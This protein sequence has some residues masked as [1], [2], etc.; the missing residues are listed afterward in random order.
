L[1]IDRLEMLEGRELLTSIIKLSFEST[2][3]NDSGQM[4][5][6]N[7]NDA[8]LYTGGESKDLGTLIGSNDGS[9]AVGINDSG[10]VVGNFFTTGGMLHVFLYSGGEMKDLGKLTLPG[11]DYGV[12]TGI[13]DSGQVVGYSDLP[14]IHTHAYLYS[15]GAMKDLGSLPG[16]VSYSIAN[17]INDSG[18]VVGFSAIPTSNPLVS[19]N[20]A[21]L[22][23]GGAM[24]DLRT[25]GGYDSGATG[26]NGSGQVVGWS[27]IRPGGASHAFLYSGG[28]MKDLGTLP[29]GYGSYATGINGSGQVVGISD[30]LGGVYH[31]FLFSDGAMK[32]LNSLLPANSGWVLGSATSINDHGQ[33]VGTGTY[34]GKAAGFLLD[35]GTDLAVSGLDLHYNYQTFV[36][37]WFKGASSGSY[38]FDG[39]VTVT[40][41]SGFVSAPTQLTVF[42]T[43]SDTYDPVGDPTYRQLAAPFQVGS[44]Q[45]GQSE[46]I[47]LEGIQNPI[48]I[49][50][51]A[52]HGFYTSGFQIMAIAGD[53]PSPNGDNLASESYDTFE[54]LTWVGMSLAAQAY[55]GGFAF[56]NGLP[57]T[58]FLAMVHYL[59]GSGTLLTFPESTSIEVQTDPMFQQSALAAT[60]YVKAYAIS[61]LKTAPQGGPL[62][63]QISQSLLGTPAFGNNGTLLIPFT[64]AEDLKIG[65]HGTQASGGV[66]TGTSSVVGT[67]AARR[68]MVTGNLVLVYAD[69]YEFDNNDV[70]ES[71]GLNTLARSLA[72]AGMAKPF[73]D[74]VV[75]TIPINMAVTFSGG[76]VKANSLTKPS[77]LPDASPAAAVATEEIGPARRRVGALTTGTGPH[78]SRATQVAPMFAPAVPRRWAKQVVRATPTAGSKG[79]L[80]P[81]L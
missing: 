11:G 66:F 77:S 22:Y 46:T 57:S 81:T 19:Y 4:I 41:K 17:G 38:G 50:D 23:S 44:L 61:K 56:V 28:E 15:G 78:A 40:N 62:S 39:Q 68:L 52:G 69:V 59:G 34:Q 5:W 51:A 29:G 1:R 16:G 35:L 64:Y 31:A 63:L 30:T 9:K 32:D 3:I 43:S 71:G 27:E 54:R 47:P 20:H 7:A 10:Q 53:T 73:V 74:E 12:A 45:P 76:S 79:A 26:I 14:F 48:L 8:Y 37:A 70:I 25:L 2:D 60:N 49:T 72:A 55:E 18:Q 58:A 6:S 33:I 13:N 42:A 21:F 24:K 67:G 36:A 65:I 80:Q 75:V